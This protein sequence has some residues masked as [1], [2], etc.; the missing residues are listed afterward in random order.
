[1]W[2]LRHQV[3]SVMPVDEGSYLDGEDVLHWHGERLVQG[4][5]RRG[6]VV[7]HGLHELKDL[8]LA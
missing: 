4:A 1:M 2:L 3:M 6:H 7:V 8:F 5:S